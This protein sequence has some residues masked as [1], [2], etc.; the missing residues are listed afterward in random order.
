MPGVGWSIIYLFVY[1]GGVVL[2]IKAEGAALK[3]WYE[4]LK[5]PNQMCTQWHDLEAMTV[6]DD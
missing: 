3:H 2:H 1:S 5:S 4:T 6:Q